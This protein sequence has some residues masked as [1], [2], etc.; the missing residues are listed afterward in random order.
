ML[1]KGINLKEK[2]GNTA[3]PLMKH[4]IATVCS[5]FFSPL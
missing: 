1:S 5:L 4:W 3:R 2:G